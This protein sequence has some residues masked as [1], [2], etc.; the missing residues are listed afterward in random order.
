VQISSSPGR[1]TPTYDLETIQQL[2]GQGLIS[3]RVTTAARYGAA[4]LGISEDDLV[5][6]V[7][8]L[9]PS[10]F[11][12]SMESEQVPGLWQ[13]VYHFPHGPAVLYVKLQIDP[14]GRAVI[15]QCKER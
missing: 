4:E 7:L 8:S 10:Y 15:I 5:E 14:L 2:V 3:Y 6:I 11:Y 13:D 1:S 9:T 12:K